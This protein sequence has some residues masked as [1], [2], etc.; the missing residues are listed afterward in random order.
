VQV[1]VAPSTV[2]PSDASVTVAGTPAGSANQ[3]ASTGA[4]GLLYA[5]GLGA[6]A[7]LLGAAFVIFARRRAVR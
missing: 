1:P 6:G 7:L 3:L 4:G 2:P 5:A